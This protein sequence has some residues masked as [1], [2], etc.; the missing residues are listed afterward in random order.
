MKLLFLDIDGV[1]NVH[2]FNKES[3]SGVI[4][5]DK[6]ERVNEILRR[7]DARVVLS[8]AWRYFVHR[9][10]MDLTGL[11]WLLRSHGLIHGRLDGITRKDR[12]NFA[13]CGDPSKW[14]ID[15]NERSDQVLEYLEP[16]SVESYVV[17]DDL[18]LGF[19]KR[20]MNFI[21]TDGLVGI[22]DEHVQKAIEIL[23]GGAS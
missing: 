10:E 15:G 9:D 20:E 14:Y 22:T 7:T 1:L 8:S 4:H 19:S 18:D 12:L 6:V 21:H 23:N 11:D 13:Y 3:M 2:D 5:R 17:I 16:R